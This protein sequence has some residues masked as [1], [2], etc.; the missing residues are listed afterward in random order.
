MTGV[1][2]RL[3]STYRVTDRGRS[4]AGWVRMKAMM[5]FLFFIL[6]LG[7]LA[8]VALQG[9]QIASQK[10]SN[11]AAIANGLDGIAGISWRPRLIGAEPVS[12]DSGIHVRIEADG[13]IKGHGG[14]NAFFGSMEKTGSNVTIGPLGTTRMACDAGVMDRE[15]AFLQALERT[16]RYDIAAGRLTLIDAGNTLLAELVPASR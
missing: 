10:T 1:L 2:L 13:S 6:F 9:R 14:C 15:L 11:S 7:G 16:H 3:W 4:W 5:G 12:D 8:F